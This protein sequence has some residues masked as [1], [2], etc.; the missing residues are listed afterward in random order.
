MLCIVQHTADLFLSSVV[1]EEK[2]VLDH[3]HNSFSLYSSPSLEFV[4]VC[5][6]IYLCGINRGNN[7]ETHD[8]IGLIT[9]T[10]DTI[11]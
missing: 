5:A 10:L 2:K 3:G 8:L 6:C 9:H 11:H 1:N 7:W 4:C